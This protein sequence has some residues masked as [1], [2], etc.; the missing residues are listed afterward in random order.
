MRVAVVLISLLPSS[1]LVSVARGGD[2]MVSLDP[3]DEPSEWRFRVAPYLWAAGISGDFAQFGLPEVEVNRS[4]SDVLENLDVG[5]MGVLEDMLSNLWILLRGVERTGEAGDNS[6]TWTARYGSVVATAYDIATVD[7]LNER[8]LMANMLWLVEAGYPE[9]DPSRPGLAVSLWAQYLLDQFATVEECIGHLRDEPF[10]LVTDVIPGT[11]RMTTV[12]LSISDRGGDSAIIEYID[13]RQVIH[14]SREHQVMTN[15]PVFEQQLALNAYWQNIGG[16]VMLPGTNRA[17]DR[18]A[19][20][21]F[22]INAI[23]RVEDRRVAM[24]GVFSVIRNVSVPFGINTEDEPNISSTRWRV[25]ADHKDLRYYFESAVS[26]NI[27]WVD[28]AG[29][30]FDEGSGSRKLD[31]GPDSGRVLAGEASE[32]FVPAPAFVFHGL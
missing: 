10:V 13:G 11:E 31:L 26:P 14:H 4:F 3:A 20:A 7:G 5:V 16:T 23:P 27:F 28:L 24:A 18:F 1:V 25:L 6:I 9:P 32:A 8:G 12:H 19:R 2:F 29:I 17:A 22:Y 21:M 30:D 15:S